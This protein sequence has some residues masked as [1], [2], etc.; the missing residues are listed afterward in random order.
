MW[1]DK[2]VSWNKIRLGKNTFADVKILN[3]K[4]SNWKKAAIHPVPPETSAIGQAIDL[5]EALLQWQEWGLLWETV[6]RYVK[7]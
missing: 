7:R 3:R 2:Y 4:Q 5:F 1:K 6:G